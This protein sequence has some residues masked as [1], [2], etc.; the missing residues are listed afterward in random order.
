MRKLNL[1]I[2]KEGFYGISPTRGTYYREAV[3][4]GLRKQG[5][6]SGVHLKIYGEFEE[7][8]ELVWKDDI[9]DAVVVSWRD[10]HNLANF[11]AVGISLL[12]AH[13][14][15]AFKAFE[16]STIGT[17]IDFFMGQS[18]FN[19][20]VPSFLQREARLEVS[21]IFEENT[22]NS[23]K[24]RIGKKRKQMKVSDHTNLNGWIIV[25]EFSTPKSKIVKK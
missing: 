17:G 10:K 4:V 24:M 15:L 22:G 11:G 3:I 14:I 1:D 6:A 21:G 16:E 20:S 13:K 19:Q 18:D 7:I 23:V 8:V 2:L 9:D 25:V 5:F 12:I